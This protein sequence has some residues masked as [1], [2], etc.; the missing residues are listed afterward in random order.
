[1]KRHKHEKA[2]KILGKIYGA[3]NQV[4][5]QEQLREIEEALQGKTTVKNMLNEF[6]TWKV[7]SR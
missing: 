5:V 1:M 2:E 4:V 6:L 3:K 7:L